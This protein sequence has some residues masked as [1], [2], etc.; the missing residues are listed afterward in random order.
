MN[1]TINSL[2]SL[3]T[4]RLFAQR[5]DLNETQIIQKLA[6]NT[7]KIGFINSEILLW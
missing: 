6:L 3:I 4:F 7:N 5:V 2:Q 1:D